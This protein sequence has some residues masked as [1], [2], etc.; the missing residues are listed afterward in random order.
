MEYEFESMKRT[1]ENLSIFRFTAE[2]KTWSI[3]TVD[4]ETRMV[5]GQSNFYYDRKAR[6]YN[7]EAIVKTFKLGEV[8]FK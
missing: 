8:K 7:N 3:K 6:N 2:G 4:F 1:I 5:T